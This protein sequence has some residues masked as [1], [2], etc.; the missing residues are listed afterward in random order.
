LK[1]TLPD[2]P[3]DRYAHLAELV[4]PEIWR[5]LA[6]DTGTGFPSSATVAEI[7]RLLATRAEVTR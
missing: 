6:H 7:I 4:G 2:L 1:T 5:I 3:A